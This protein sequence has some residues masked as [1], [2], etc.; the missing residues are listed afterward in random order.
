VLPK[1]SQSGRMCV[2]SRKLSLWR[3]NATN[4]GQSTTAAR[5]SA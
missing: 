3:I 5:E 2:V 4:R 1:A